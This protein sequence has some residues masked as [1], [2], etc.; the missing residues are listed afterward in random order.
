MGGVEGSGEQSQLLLPPCVLQ[1]CDEMEKGGEQTHPL[2]TTTKLNEVSRH[3]RRRRK[4][5]SFRSP[6][7]TALI[8]RG[9]TK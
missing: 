8:M 4:K 2:T 5:Q 3:Q 9:A 1:V 6:N 7:W